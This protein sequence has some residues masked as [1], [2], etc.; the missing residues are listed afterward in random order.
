MNI[1]PSSPY[2]SGHRSVSGIDNPE[3]SS[4]EECMTRQRSVTD[5]V[6]EHQRSATDV[7]SG[8]RRSYRDVLMG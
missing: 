3:M 2:H 1:D 4:P 6:E 5:A 7:I 8:N